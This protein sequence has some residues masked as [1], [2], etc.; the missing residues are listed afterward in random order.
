MGRLTRQGSPSFVGPN[1]FE[2]PRT[3]VI[4]REESCE[5]VISDLSVSR[6]HARLAWVDGVWTVEDLGGANGTTVQGSRVLPEEPFTLAEGDEIRFGNGPVWILS[7]T[8]PP[9]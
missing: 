7:S 8:A 9:A 2:L 5:M 6:R 3:G 1:E 4:G